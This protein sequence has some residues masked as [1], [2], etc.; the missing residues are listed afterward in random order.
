MKPLLWLVPLVVV[1]GSLAG[2]AMA[3][4]EMGWLRGRPDLARLDTSARDAAS[5]ALLPADQPQPRVQIDQTEF[6]FG[7]ME[8]N[9]TMQ[10]TF[11]IKNVGRGP[12]SLSKGDT[13]CKCTISQLSEGT[14]PPGGQTEIKLEWKATTG[15]PYFRQSATILTNDP[16]HRQIKLEV[17][18]GIDEPVHWYPKSEIVFGGLMPDQ[19]GRD[20]LKLLTSLSDKLEVLEHRLDDPE[21]ARFIDVQW[22][23]LPASELQGLL[24]AKAGLNFEVRIKP[25]LPLGR[26]H[27]L[28]EFTTNVTAE[29]V[30]LPI[31]GNV[32]TG[33]TVFGQGWSDARETLS[34]GTVSR[35]E[36]AVRKLQIALKGDRRHDTKLRVARVVP[37]FLQVEL[38]EP[39]DGGQTVRV[40]ITVT[41]PK[42]CPVAAYVG[43]DD[44][45]LGEIDLET[46]HPDFPT[47]QLRVHVIVEG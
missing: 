3:A 23:P 21:L 43:S 7:T 14:V 12:L 8:L 30:A 31:S 33:I 32:E 44:A 5:P 13:T 9:S 16:F 47:L 22:T 38:G 27:Q 45:P 2:A 37:D 39:A 41:I 17:Y 15:A 34:F 25:G 6:D 46:G 19:E 18:G 42:N 36:G 10:H 1:L 35:A 24:G 20:S 40:P 26:F 28:V 29:R 11:V 4:A